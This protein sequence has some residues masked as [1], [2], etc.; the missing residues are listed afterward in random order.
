MGVA[1]GSAMTGSAAEEAERAASS[2]A[3]LIHILEQL[4]R[5]VGDTAEQQP[6]ALHLERQHAVT[7]DKGEGEH[8]QRRR[9][10]ARRITL[11]ERHGDALVGVL[12]PFGEGTRN[13]GAEAWEL[14]DE[15]GGVACREGDD[16]GR[17]AGTE[18]GA[19]GLVEQDA[20]LTGGHTGANLGDGDAAD[21]HV[22]L[23][24]DHEIEVV[25]AAVLGG[26][27]LAGLKRPELGAG[28]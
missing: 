21:N 23:P 16:A 17:N 8:G 11:V 20:H 9:V 7:A 2:A 22:E 19:A 26:E 5:G 24:F 14:L 6:V 3:A 18:R 25:C 13:G 4:G 1:L 15:V 27:H 10:G 28:L 12:E